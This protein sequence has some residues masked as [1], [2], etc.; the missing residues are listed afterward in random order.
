MRAQIKAT[1]LSGRLCVLGLIALLI[2]SSFAQAPPQQSDEQV[3]NETEPDKKA[4]GS[5][6][7]KKEMMT[8]KEMMKKQEMMKADMLSRMGPTRQESF[9]RR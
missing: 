3:A 8:K 9:I 5:P 2:G 6:G 7:Q 4:P 1:R